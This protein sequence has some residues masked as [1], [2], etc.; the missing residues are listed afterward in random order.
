MATTVVDYTFPKNS[1]HTSVPASETSGTT[2]IAFSGTFELR[3]GG[4][5][6]K[7]NT[8]T[9]TVTLSAA[10]TS[11]DSIYLHWTGQ[12]DGTTHGPIVAIG[13]KTVSDA[14]SANNDERILAIAVGGEDGQ[15]NVAGET[16]IKIYRYGGKSVM[17]RRL[18]VVSDE[19][20]STE[21]EEEEKPEQLVVSNDMT[22]DWTK[23]SAGADKV[24]P[25][26]A[27]D[28]ILMSTIEGI[29]TN[30]SQFDA[31]YIMLCG[32]N[33][34]RNGDACQVSWLMLKLAKPGK[35]TVKFCNVGDGGKGSR[36]LF[37]NGENT[38]VFS[39]STETTGA[40]LV[41]KN[42]PAGE[43]V[44]TAQRTDKAGNQAFR[45]MNLKYTV[46]ETTA[47]TSVQEGGILCE[48][49][50]IR[51]ADVPTQVLTVAGQQVLSTN[52]DLPLSSL[53]HGVYIVR[54]GAASMK[55]AR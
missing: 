9:V 49:G 21:P 53:K 27:T 41:E 8:D 1:T 50:V 6:L 38:G 39:D 32:E 31:R 30:Y 13:G 23:A 34:V 7:T 15:M 52:D 36:Y 54:Q 40:K 55:L 35:I 26:V 29:T 20:G 33:A 10:L 42:V 18:V 2:T 43:L 17:L 11:A 46:S 5:R 45:I 47:L 4:I 48:N 25:A 19:G 37:I 44:F 22:W 3:S 12:S 24:S 16:V 28:T 51:H 14:S